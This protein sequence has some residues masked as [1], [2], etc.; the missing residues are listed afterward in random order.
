MPSG[1]F[2]WRF[3]N[4]WLS[5][6]IRASWPFHH[7][8][9][10]DEVCIPDKLRFNAVPS[11]P[12]HK[13]P[14]LLMGCL[15]VDMSAVYHTNSIW[16]FPH[17]IELELDPFDLFWICWKLTGQAKA[18]DTLCTTEQTVD[19]WHSVYYRADCGS[20]ALC[21]LQSRLW[22]SGTLCTTEQTV[23]LWTHTP[24]PMAW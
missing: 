14:F 11:F 22:I 19:L 24:S 6:R 15:D 4:I 3:V 7:T 2:C 1:G 21:V 5:L 20:L 9:G 10:Y 23:D 13:L 8:V 16:H 18:D 17:F 12:V